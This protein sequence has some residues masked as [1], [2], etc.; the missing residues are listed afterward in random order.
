MDAWAEE[1]FS[2]IV[3]S[4]WVSQ[5]T[6]RGLC[7]VHG[8]HSLEATLKHPDDNILMKC[9]AGCATEA[10]LAALGLR[11]SDLFHPSRRHI[12]IPRAPRRTVPARVLND[13]L[14]IEHRII[15]IGTFDRKRSLP[16]SDGDEA[17]LILAEKR[18][19]MA[20]GLIPWE[21]EKAPWKPR[22]SRETPLACMNAELVEAAHAGDRDILARQVRG[23]INAED[24]WSLPNN[25]FLESI[26]E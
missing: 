17:R 8:G 1:V 10:V 4:R 26:N 15:R 6:L 5:V 20:Q 3:E 19:F 18:L 14:D 25:P 11:F 22:T 2:R 7:P 9:R 21:L 24:V 16:I 12:P 13:A 23:L